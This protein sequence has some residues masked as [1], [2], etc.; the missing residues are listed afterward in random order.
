MSC[1]LVSWI[2]GLNPVELGL[3]FAGVAL[4]G[5]VFTMGFMTQSFKGAFVSG[6]VFFLP[7]GLAV[8]IAQ[9]YLIEPAKR[10]LVRE[11]DWEHPKTAAI[12]AGLFISLVTVLIMMVTVTI[13]FGVVNAVQSPEGLAA[14]FDPAKLPVNILS[15]FY[16]TLVGL[17][18]G[19]W[20]WIP[21][22]I[23][24]GIWM[25]PQRP[26]SQNS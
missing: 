11:K 20:V 24:L 8:A 6:G 26:E 10:K 16:V 19:S 25:R 14:L 23:G 7:L 1:K 12:T 9:R 22:G 13:G 15:L 21:V 2:R 5:I 17:V 18:I 3:F 4:V